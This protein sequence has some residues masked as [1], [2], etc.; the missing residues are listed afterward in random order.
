MTA[1]HVH[2]TTQK[3]DTH[4][5]PY[6]TC[7]ATLFTLVGLLPYMWLAALSGGCSKVYR[8]DTYR[9]LDMV[10]SHRQCTIYLALDLINI[11][12]TLAH[13]SLLGHTRSLHYS[14]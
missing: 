4:M 7:L 10:C 12:D 11:D 6:L 5:T 3:S 8:Y 9:R 14:K 13:R 2:M 1:A